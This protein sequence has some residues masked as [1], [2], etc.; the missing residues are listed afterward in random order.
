[1]K[2]TKFFN[3]LFSLLCIS[4]FVGLNNNSCFADEV[5]KGYGVNI[6]INDSYNTAK[7]KFALSNVNAAHSD[8][9]N[10]IN[11]ADNKTFTLLNHALLLAEY[12]F[13]DLTDEIFSKI[14]D[15]EISQNYIADIKN[16]YYPAKK[17]TQEELLYLA[18]AYS[19]IM[20]N[21]YAQ[22]TVL[23]IVN[24]GKLFRTPNDYIYYILALGYFET[25]DLLQALNYITLATS[26][27]GNNLN[28]K[29]LKT[30]ILLELGQ[31]KKA[32]KLLDEIKRQKFSIED[33]R[34]KI[35]ALEQFVL[36]K[37]A[38]N[39]KLKDYHLGYYYYLE[40]KVS[41]AQKVLLNA[42]SNNKKIN[43]EIYALLAETYLSTDLKQA[44]EYA[45]KS[46]RCG[47]YTEFA[48]YTLG[49][50]KMSN[51][52]FKAAAKNFNRAAILDKNSPRSKIKIAEINMQKNK[53]KQTK[54]QWQNLA[55]K[56]PTNS[57]VYTHLSKYFAD[58]KELLLKKSLS[59]DVNNIS[60]YYKLAEIYINRDNYNLAK[61]Y[62]RNANNIDETDFRYYYYL[63]RIESLQ[64][65][66]VQ[67]EE[68]LE[69]CKKLEPD[70]EERLNRDNQ[71]E[72]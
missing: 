43:G 66:F 45:L 71:I 35:N 50:A 5:I 2:R 19:N 44:E 60:A 6:G 46:L 72:E 51:K 67:A 28:Y 18:E 1:M 34:N 56:H 8:F 68:L 15:Y 59:Y 62:L 55:K 24:N 54:K 7:N 40:D 26:Q 9:Q 16:F 58:N 25:K 3:T 23:D 10:I 63:S 47:I 36:Y 13:F 22:E 30:K 38:K 57:L 27:N 49:L 4:C 48:Y 14:D 32:V 12:G 29:I 65:N 70:Y 52:Q 11:S 69:H 64:G 53:E 21:N 17:M 61:Q 37:T 42:I 20:Y 39:E 31:T 33:L 41:F